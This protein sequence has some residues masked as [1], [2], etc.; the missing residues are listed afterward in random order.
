MTLSLPETKNR[1]EIEA[2]KADW[3]RDPMWDLPRTEGF[4]AYREE[5]QLYSDRMTSQWDHEYD[6]KL[7]AKARAIGSPENKDL[8]EYILMLEQRVDALNDRL[9][10]LENL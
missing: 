7:E 1:S 6:L 9:T 2:L 4:E 8:A 10:R 3:A 5:L